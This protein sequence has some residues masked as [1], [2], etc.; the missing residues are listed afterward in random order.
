MASISEEVSMKKK[1]KKSMTG[2]ELARLI[3]QLAADKQEENEGWRRPDL[4][5][6]D[7]IDRVLHESPVLRRR[8]F[9]NPNVR[10]FFASCERFKRG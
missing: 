4:I 3:E 8:F 5:S 9:N 10:A 2:P 7:A 6:H 1:K